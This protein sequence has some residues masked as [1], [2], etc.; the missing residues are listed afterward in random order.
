M[1]V[2]TIALLVLLACL[3]VGQQ[4]RFASDEALWSEA[5]VSNRTSPRAAF[6]LAKALR[7]QGRYGQAVGWL[8]ETSRRAE[9]HPDASV[10]RVAVQTQ[11]LAMEMTGF[12]ACDSD[13]LHSYC[14]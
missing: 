13:W 8:V 4:R 5:V 9:G 11:F 14:Y 7:E 1:A 12:R 6:N 2:K 3:T 10:F